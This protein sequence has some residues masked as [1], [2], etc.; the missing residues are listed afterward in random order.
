MHLETGKKSI[1]KSQEE[2]F[3]FLSDVS[4]FKTIMPDSLQKF[5]VLVEDT[6]RFGLSGMPEIV[7]KLK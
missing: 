5:E 4:N 3:N 2:T 6:F 7:L 1:G